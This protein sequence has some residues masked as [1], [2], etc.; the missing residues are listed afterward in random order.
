MRKRERRPIK[1]EMSLARKLEEEG[2]FEKMGGKR[3]PT[4]CVC[5]WTN[6]RKK[7]KSI[8]SQN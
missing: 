4:W 2:K 1:A 5:V 6:D 3:L 7:G 8:F